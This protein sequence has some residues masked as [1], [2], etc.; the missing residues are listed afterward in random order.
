[1]AIEIALGVLGGLGLFLYGMNL[2]G[3][4][5]QKAAGEKLK[6]IIELLTS[7]R[8][9]GVLVGMFVTAIIQSSSATTVMVV[10]FVNAGIMRLT[11]AIGVIMGANIGTTVT[12]QLVSFELTEL[13]PIAVGLG[14]IIYLFSTK[15][16]NKQLAEILIGF[17]ILFIG[18]DFMK[19]A[20]KPLREFPAF[21][22]MLVGFG[23]KTIL[24][25]FMGFAMTVILQ[26]SSAAMGILLALSSEGLLPL[27]SAL[28]ILY[29]QNIG[30]CITA[31]LSSIGASKNAKRA[32]VMHMTF[33]IIGTLLFA[34]ILN[35]PTISIVTKLNPDDVTRQIANAHTL[36]NVLNVVILFPFASLIVKL[37]VKLIPET[38]DEYN[39]KVTKYLDDRI[40]E[41]PSIALANTVRESL[42]MGNVARKSLENSMNG[43]F[44]WSKEEVEKTF[45]KEKKVNELQREIIDYLIQLSNRAISVENREIV[46]GLFN[47]VSDIERVGD[48]A[49]NIA[50]LAI[51]AIEKDIP[52]S[53]EGIKELKI[54]FDKVMTAYKCSLKAM[55]NKDIDLAFNVIKMEEQIDIME[56]SCRKSHI[57]RLNNSLCN[58][59]SGIIFLDMISN[60]ER[61]GDHSSNIARAVIDTQT[62]K[63][64]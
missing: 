38:E 17:G 43:F 53:D 34:I 11:Q 48:H 4:G 63:Q 62:V 60:M 13:A 7:N 33:N 22:H 51:E 26:S 20:V 54:M 6:R 10:G 29:G 1:M 41:T 28:P 27:A 16:K 30:T 50:E 21:R 55:K 42:H 25:I 32:A 45:E 37:A 49:D 46:D 47:T 31:I 9:M 61:I 23:D 12:A 52:F 19:N 8:F 56:K 18:M 58:P 64:T 44:N 57:Y 3:E 36:F 2:M 35:N 5:L 14:M 15:Q 39:D 59:E 24:G 40:L